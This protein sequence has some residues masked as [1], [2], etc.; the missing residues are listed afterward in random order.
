MLVEKWRFGRE[1]SLASTWLCTTEDHSLPYELQRTLMQRGE[2]FAPI[3]DGG[4]ASTSARVDEER[5]LALFSLMLAQ[6]HAGA[7]TVLVDELD[8]GIQRHFRRDW[9]GLRN[10]T[11]SPV[12]F[13]SID[14]IPCSDFPQATRRV[15]F[16]T[17]T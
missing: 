6:A 13:S 3:A 9:R 11:P 2:S 15:I 14:S 1:R 8:V 4:L 16:R 10:R 17:G 7:A 5:Q 12:P